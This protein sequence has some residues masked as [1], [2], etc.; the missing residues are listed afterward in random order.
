L[1][2]YLIHSPLFY[3]DQKKRIHILESDEEEEDDDEKIITPQINQTKNLAT[4][5]GWLEKTSHHHYSNKKQTKAMKNPPSSH[6]ALSAT[7]SS[8]PSTKKSKVVHD[9]DSG[10]SEIEIFIRKHPESS[11]SDEDDE[12]PAA[13][14]SV[15]SSSSSFVKE[16]SPTVIFQLQE[17][18]LTKLLQER[19]NQPKRGG[20]RFQKRSVQGCSLSHTTGAAGAGKPKKSSVGRLLKKRIRSLSLT[21]SDVESIE[22]SGGLPQ[23]RVVDSDEEVKPLKG[24]RQEIVV[25]ESEDE[26]TSQPKSHKSSNPKPKPIVVEDLE[27]DE[28]GVGDGD[29]DEGS[30]QSE[31][32]D[33]DEGQGSD[34]DS[35]D[36]VEGEKWYGGGSESD[37]SGG[38]DGEEEERGEYRKRKRRNGSED[39]KTE[40]EIQKEIERKCRRVLQRCGDVSKLLRQALLSWSS[41]H[42]ATPGAPGGAEDSNQIGSCVNLISIQ[43][44]NSNIVTQELVTQRISPKLALKDYQLVGLNWLKLM[45]TNDVNG[46]LAD[47]M[48]L[49]YDDLSSSHSSSVGQ[50]NRSNDCLRCLAALRSPVKKENSSHASHRRPC[51]H[52]RQLDSRICK[53]LSSFESCSLPWHSQ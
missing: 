45:H 9:S 18:N 14:A 52:S 20:H 12:F 5:S 36:T 32:S 29:E 2:S 35:E 33:R 17:D 27:S 42:G 26:E 39:E 4:S 48:G 40:E 43:D 53:I 19:E 15:S 31:D 1:P 11:P 41:P 50:E 34:N 8:R 21:D 38:G 49:G 16:I 10:E 13:S 6:Q 37:G 24:G 46:V 30:F 47:D 3:R 22:S 28:E 44:Q 51:L 23:E 25:L 7:A